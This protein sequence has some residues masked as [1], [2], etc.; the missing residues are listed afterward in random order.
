MA[1]QGGIR[2]GLIVRGPAGSIREEVVRRMWQLGRNGGYF[3]GPD[4]SMPWPAEHIQAL[5]Q[6]VEELGQYPLQEPPNP[7]WRRDR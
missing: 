4:Q 7:Y 2:S 3:C 1:L 5:Y 6:A